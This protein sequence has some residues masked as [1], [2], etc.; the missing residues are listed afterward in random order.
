[1]KISIVSTYGHGGA[2]IAARRLYDAIVESGVSADLVVK[3]YKTS[4]SWRRF[5]KKLSDNRSLVVRRDILEKKDDS[6]ETFSFS[7]EFSCQPELLD[8]D[9]I[10][11]NWISHFIDWKRFFR[12]NNEKKYVWTLHDMN[13]FTGG[14][15]HSDECSQYVD[16][17]KKCPQ[18]ENSGYED[19]VE[20]FFL[21]K[22][23]AL[24]CLKD[25]QM[26]VVGPSK[27]IT[28]LS[29]KSRL[30][31]RFEHR[32]INNCVPEIFKFIDKSSVR[33]ALKLPNDKKIIL[34]V[35]E[36]LDNKRKNLGVLMEVLEKTDENISFY[37]LGSKGVKRDRVNYSGF[38]DDEETMRDW[39]CASDLLI[40]PSIAEN[41]PNT[42]AE[43]NCSGTP[44]V[45]FPVGGHV[46]MIL[47]GTNGFLTNDI[48]ADSLRDSIERALD[49]DF[50]RQLI[51]SDGKKRY[52]SGD[53]LEE[54]MKIYKEL[55]T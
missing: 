46:E 38:I 7:E 33:K 20:H 17:C 41:L 11:L 28:K 30:L 10:H 16:G 37:A 13:P 18:L 47:S 54:Y 55:A 23:K 12:K 15:H 3:K 5:L 53:V 1:L 29:E 4:K 26:V 40:N 39:Y 51:A 24:S 43:A 2:G 42:V 34:F 31:G 45:A 8:T 48:S 27:W 44:V 36:K 6:R 25:D 50:D 14:C 52:N 32:Q 19:R 21:E 49:W 35:A 9:I 22:E